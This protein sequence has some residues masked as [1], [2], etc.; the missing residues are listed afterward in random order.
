MTRTDAKPLV[1]LPV[2][3][4]T[5][6]F[7]PAGLIEAGVLL[8]RLQEGEALGMPQSRPLPAIAADCHELRLH[9]SDFSWRI[10]HVVDAD[11]IVILEVFA[12]ETRTTPADVIEMCKERLAAQRRDGDN[13]ANGKRAAS[14]RLLE[15]GW[16]VGSAYEFLGLSD[17]DAALVDMRLGLSRALRAR[18]LATGQSQAEFAMKTGSSQAQILKMESADAAISLDL[19]VRMLLSVGASAADIAKALRTRRLHY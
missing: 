10:V 8:R 19:L 5:P 1:W 12:K 14:K 2:E 16:C 11:A 15:A 4:E 7:S 18:R 3:I 6:L 17:A 13:G 9:S